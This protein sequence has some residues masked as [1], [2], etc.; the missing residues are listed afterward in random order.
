M[1]A[2][3]AVIYVHGRDMEQVATKLS[4]AMD[5]KSYWL[6][7]SCLTLN[8]EKTV[9]IYLAKS[10]KVKDIPNIYFNGQKNEH[11]D[12]DKISRCPN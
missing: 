12:R 5:K 3:D 2:D 4:S 6:N 11:R 1:Y 9:G 10:K 8:V 7:S